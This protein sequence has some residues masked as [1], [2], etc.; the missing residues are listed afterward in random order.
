MAKIFVIET[1]LDKAAVELES[2]TF[3]KAF[4][5]FF[6]QHFAAF[7]SLLSSFKNTR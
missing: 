4:E 3:Q 2:K 6:M 5:T 1:D 7:T